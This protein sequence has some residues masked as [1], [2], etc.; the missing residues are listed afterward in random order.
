MIYAV[1]FLVILSMVA[2]SVLVSESEIFHKKMRKTVVIVAILIS[3]E[4]IIGSISDWMG[5][6]GN[7]GEKI[8]WFH[9]T[10]KI[11]QFCIGPCIP[12]LFNNIITGK[13]AYKTVL[14]AYKVILPVNI[15]LQ[16]GNFFK[17]L[18]FSIDENN[19][20]H[21][22]PISVLYV[23]IYLSSM[24]LMLS[25]IAYFNEH[26]CQ[27]N[28]KVG[29]FVLQG[30]AVIGYSIQLLFPTFRTDWLVTAISFLLLILYYV[31]MNL[32]LDPLTSLLNKRSYLLAI[33]NINFST[34]I[35]IIDSNKFKCVN[36]K[37][38]HKTGDD[39]LKEIAEAIMKVYDKIG[40]CY[41]IGGDEFAVILKKGKLEQ[42]ADK[43]NYQN[44]FI[45]IN[46]YEEKL[47]TILKNWSDNR[48]YLK[49][50]VSQGFAVYYESDSYFIDY[51]EQI[52]IEK[53]IEKSDK[54]MYKN[55]LLRTKCNIKK[56]DIS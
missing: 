9:K 16:I 28:K 55:K 17:P 5:N 54:E 8:I 44:K 49:F 20:F 13:R 31:N 22:E 46:E 41:R 37:Y 32:K 39:A 50:G 7:L 12:Y 45:K 14:R 42:L 35:I 26:I 29:L 27:S 47:D 33:K 51:S 21:R 52:P 19:K 36:D 3:I 25:A 10:I 18:V 38:G 53:V 11:I 23:I 24:V 1:S 48:E 34:A 43:N 30:F 6:A 15:A 40:R 56:Y 2:I 4:S